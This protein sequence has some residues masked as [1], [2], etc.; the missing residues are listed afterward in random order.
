MTIDDIARSLLR[1]AEKYGGASAVR[2]LAE[3]DIRMFDDTY[4]LALAT[5]L[6]AAASERMKQLERFHQ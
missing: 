1:E 3:A 6:R 2:E 5:A 4:D